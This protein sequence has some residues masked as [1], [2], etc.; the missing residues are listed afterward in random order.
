M[1]VSVV[2]YGPIDLNFQT[3][4]RARSH[5]VSE[6]LTNEPLLAN[7]GLDEGRSGKEIWA[8]NLYRGRISISETLVKPELFDQAYSHD[9]A[10]LWL[11]ML[12]TVSKM[13]KSPKVEHLKALRLSL[14]DSPKSI[15]REVF[16]MV[17]VFNNSFCTLSFEPLFFSKS[18][19][20]FLFLFLLYLKQHKAPNVFDF[21]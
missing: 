10:P 20:R 14:N 11:W 5:S 1:I 3:V 17:F 7:I 2:T 13:G 12:K 18:F 16:C 15:S 19:T 6:R 4:R 21:S 8:W 9:E